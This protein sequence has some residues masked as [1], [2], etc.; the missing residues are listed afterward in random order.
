M[1][2]DE[3]SAVARA[4]T[5]FGREKVHQIRIASIR[6]NH[7]IDR[8]VR[9]ELGK[10]NALTCDIRVSAP[11]DLRP[12]DHGV[13]HIFG[14]PSDANAP[15]VFSLTCNPARLT[16]PSLLGTPRLNCEW[17]KLLMR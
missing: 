15:G 1:I 9:M 13:V 6:P 5:G 3:E 2:Y 17:R 12:K 7:P 10:P 11:S 4:P 14:F 8:Q 16:G